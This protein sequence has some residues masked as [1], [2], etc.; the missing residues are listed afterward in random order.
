MLKF[1]LH[2]HDGAVGNF[3]LEALIRFYRGKAVKA[4]RNYKI[5]IKS[6]LRLDLTLPGAFFAERNSFIFGW[7]S[8]GESPRERGVVMRFDFI[9]S[10]RKYSVGEAET[11]KKS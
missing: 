8:F 6:R 2:R 7:I 1:P 5:N 4:T 3:W 10:I 11:S 9:Y